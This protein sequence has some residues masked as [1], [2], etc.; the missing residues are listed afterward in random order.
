MFNYLYFKSSPL[1]TLK[2]RR[3]L[4]ILKYKTKFQ[5][6]ESRRSSAVRLVTTALTRSLDCSAQRR[7][8]LAREVE[9]EVFTACNNLVGSRY[10]KL[11]RKVVFGLRGD[12][13]TRDQLVVVGEKAASKIV[14]IYLRD[15]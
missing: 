12:P 5:E 3:N 10:R 15:S 1:S 14:K 2:L 7:E 6:T 9:K 11:T 4:L 8:E 13:E